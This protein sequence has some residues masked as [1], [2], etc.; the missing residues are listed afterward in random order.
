MI[1]PD[2]RT[3]QGWYVFKAHE[4]GAVGLVFYS[5]ALVDP[6]AYA[7]LMKSLSD[8]DITT[9]IIPMPLDLAIFGIDTAADVIAAFPEITTWFIGGHSL[10][11]AMAAQFV[12]ENPAAV[13]AMVF[14]ASFPA[15]NVDLSRLPI[16]S[17]TLVG[18][19]NGLAVNI[20]MESL[21]RLPPDSRLV[22]IEGGNHAQFGNYDPKA[23]D[24]MATINR[25]SQQKQAAEAVMALMGL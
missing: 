15:D 16:K 24:G 4:P 10:G 23:G 9:V 25:E 22:I 2:V 7:P 19:R 21:S 6:A 20:F 14:M 8:R 5:G 13:E 3:S 12:H 18:T 17:L 11:G 1:T